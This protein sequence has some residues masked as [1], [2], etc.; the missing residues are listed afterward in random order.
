MISSSKKIAHT[1]RAREP[2]SFSTAVLG[3]DHLYRLLR[4]SDCSGYRYILYTA[5]FRELTVRIAILPPKHQSIKEQGNSSRK[6]LSAFSSNSGS[7]LI[8]HH[9]NSPRRYRNHRY[10]FVINT[11]SIALDK[12]KPPLFAIILED[13]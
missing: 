4:L 11:E 6:I 9:C 3:F 7:S 1:T 5:A 2:L 13:A 8:T 12:E 10:R